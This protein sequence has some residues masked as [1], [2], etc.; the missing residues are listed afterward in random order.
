M[1]TADGGPN[2]LSD[3][4]VSIV[5][6]EEGFRIVGELTD[7]NVH[8]LTAA[9]EP[10]LAAGRGLTLDLEE[11]SFLDAAALHVIV[12]MASRLDGRGVVVLSSPHPWVRKVIGLVGVERLSN[13]AIVE[14]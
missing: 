2:G 1:F 8:L 3:L 7:A 11:L 14:G 10:S 13:L 4:S 9:A 5:E 12:D 6:T